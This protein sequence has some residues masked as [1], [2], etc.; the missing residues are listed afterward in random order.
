MISGTL[1]YK[2]HKKVYDKEYHKT[3]EYKAHHKIYMMEYNKKP[4]QIERRKKYMK[5]YDKTPKRIKSKKE[6]DKK[7]NQSE[8]G[9]IRDNKHQAKRR[10]QLGWIPLIDNPFPENVPIHWHHVDDTFVIPVPVDIHMK[11]FGPHHREKMLKY[12]KENK[13]YDNRTE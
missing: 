9:R 7:Y 6:R 13:N 5:E 11:T 3:L 1:E 8:K 10:R 2:L 4:E 12:I